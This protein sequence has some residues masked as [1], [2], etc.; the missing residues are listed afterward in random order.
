MIT[1]QIQENYR[2]N[3][4]KYN[5]SLIDVGEIIEDLAEKGIVWVLKDIKDITKYEQIIIDFYLNEYSSKQVYDNLEEIFNSQTSKN[6]QVYKLPTSHLSKKQLEVI[7]SKKQK[8]YLEEKDVNNFIGY[9]KAKLLE[10]KIHVL[11]NSFPLYEK[12][13]IVDQISRS[14]SSIK[15][16][17]AKGEQK[18]IGEKFKQYSMAIG[19]AKETSAWLQISLGQKYITNEQYVDLDNLVNQIVSI[20][21][22]TLCNIRENEG[23]SMCLP[24][25]Y[26]PNVKDFGAYKDALLLVKKIYEITRKREFWQEKKLQY[27][28]RKSAT[29]T[30]SNIA[31]AQQLYVPVKIRFFN[32][33]IEAL[34]GLESKLETSLMKKL[35]SKDEYVEVID[36]MKSIRKVLLKT[37]GNLR[38]SLAS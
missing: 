36:L 4:E 29:S 19:S 33:A 24:S 27:G 22:K 21:T 13:H 7:P 15:E 5:Y 17:I 30:V 8:I 26:T 1:D 37:M 10:E 34:N 14:S 38:K 28:M 2:K 6:P 35:F 23:K 12:H 32:K 11:C 18:Y 16:R 31:E 9:K 3:R 20:L 25:P